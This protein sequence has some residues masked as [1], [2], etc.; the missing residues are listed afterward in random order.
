MQKRVQGFTLIE[1][2]IVVVIIGIL[3]MV[4]YPSYQQ[5][6]IKTNR[7]VA[8]QFMLMISNK[9]EQYLLDNRSY[10]TTIGS[11]GLGLTQPSETN[12]KYTFSVALT[13]KPYVITATAIGTQ[14]SDGNL[15]LDSEG[16]K[17]PSG[18]W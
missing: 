13:P 1:V 15:T 5:H 4:A 18:K 14:A 10:T 6:V 2:M 11:G 7:S 9:Q 16:T 17:S 3:T 8:Q 12:G